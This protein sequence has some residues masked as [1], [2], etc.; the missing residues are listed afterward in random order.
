M[1]IS[2]TDWRGIVIELN[3]DEAQ[4]LANAVQNAGAGGTAAVTGTLV[5]LGVAAAIAA[6][7]AAVLIAQ[8]GWIVLA[9]R[10]NDR[11]EGVILTLPPFPP[12]VI[13]AYPRSNVNLPNN[14]AEQPAGAFV[15]SGGDVVEWRVERNHHPD[16]TVVFRLEN[17][18]QSGWEKIVVVRDGEG[19]SWEV[20]AAVN[21]GGEESLWTHQCQNGQQFSFRKPATFGWWITAFAIGG[22]NPLQRG[23][24]VVFRWTK[25]SN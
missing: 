19:S 14:W 22:L 23:D 9:I 8:I 21:G 10:L 15:S 17:V 16:D 1:A 24:R 6:P 12:G 20:K 5:G 13:L 3:H 7:V 11:G 25:D 2:I 18:C 4:K